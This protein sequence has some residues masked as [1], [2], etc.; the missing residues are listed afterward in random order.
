M[1]ARM[2]EAASL[3]PAAENVDQQTRYS[4]PLTPS[5]ANLAQAADVLCVLAFFRLSTTARAG[6]WALF[7]RRLEHAYEEGPR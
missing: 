7:S 6:F 3:A 2:K 4:S 1:I 5:M